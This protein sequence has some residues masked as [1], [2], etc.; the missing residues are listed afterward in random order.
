MKKKQV[1]SFILGSAALVAGAAAYA[2][3]KYAGKKD[4]SGHD[5]ENDSADTESI[6]EQVMLDEAPAHEEVV[7]DEAAAPE[8][9]VLDEAPVHEEVVL[10]KED[11]SPEFHPYE[12]Y[13]PAEEE[14]GP[15]N[16]E[17]YIEENPEEKASL[18]SVGEGFAAEGVKTD[19][20][21]ADNTMFFDF[22]MT[23]VDDKETE[24]IL[25][26]DLEQFLNDQTENY[27]GI[28]RQIEEDTGFSGIKMIVIFMDANED[29][30]VSGHYDETGR[31]L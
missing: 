1:I 8:E 20:S 21:F 29:E 14:Q 15:S 5:A 26:P 27:K 22:V 17:E 10:Q 28:V 18:D 6:P 23:D 4:V 2:A 16:L 24:E 13:A 25:K 9:V 7:L 30:I 19:I 12:S 31:T 3:A 11:A